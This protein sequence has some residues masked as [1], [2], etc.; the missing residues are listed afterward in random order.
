MREPTPC[1]LRER[2]A[3]DE[4]LQAP[5]RLICKDSRVEADGQILAPPGPPA[6]GLP[7]GLSTPAGLIL[8]RV[9]RYRPLTLSEVERGAVS[10]AGRAYRKRSAPARAHVN[11]NHVRAQPNHAV[12]TCGFV[13]T[14]VW[15][16][17][18]SVPIQIP[19]G[20][21]RS[22][23]PTA[24]QCRLRSEA[25]QRSPRP[26]PIG[27]S[28]GAV[29]ADVLH[30]LAPCH[31]ARSRARHRRSAPRLPDVST[32]NPVHEVARPSGAPLGGLKTFPDSV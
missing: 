30:E 10:G 28:S 13:W 8:L 25:T 17:A 22:R 19:V 26:R 15:H 18:T 23:C 1:F 12:H 11:V 4:S 14:C 27:C 20:Y 6:R 21:R 31:A 2:L 16:C 32:P 29:A 24:S 5:R 7:Y 9:R 3:H